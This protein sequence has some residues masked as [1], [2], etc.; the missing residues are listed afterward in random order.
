VLLQRRARTLN[1]HPG[2]VSFPGGRSEAE[3]VDAAATALRE[4][5]EETG[6]DPSGVEVLASL[7]D[8][9]LAA[10]NHLVTPVL[11]GGACRRASLRSTTPRLWRC[12]GP[13]RAAA[14]PRQPVH[15]DAEPRWRDR[16]GVRHRRHDRVGVSPPACWTAC[17]RPPGGRSRDRSVE[18]PITLEARPHRAA[19][20]LPCCRCR[21][22]VMP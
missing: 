5:Q 18:R 21:D 19:A 10:S 1:S 8:L 9:P 6:L 22:A 2:Q 20:V 13:G 3:D 12:S 16:A 14:R 17:S 11:P 15:L 7:P 4:A